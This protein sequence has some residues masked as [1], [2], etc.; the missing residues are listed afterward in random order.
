MFILSLFFVFHNIVFGQTE[1][2]HSSGTVWTNKVS[3]SLSTWKQIPLLSWGWAERTNSG[4]VDVTGSKGVDRRDR[5][6]A[7]WT[8]AWD[9]L[10]SLLLLDLHGQTFHVRVF[11]V[12]TQV[13][14]AEVEVRA[15]RRKS[16]G[17]QRHRLWSER[18]GKRK[19]EIKW[20]DWAKRSMNKNRLIKHYHKSK[21]AVPNIPVLKWVLANY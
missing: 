17:R 2:G 4:S 11:E 13:L 10:H 21:S 5:D 3:G 20:A 9:G 12:K 19:N 1:S 8:D 18:E 7:G 16:V 14:H 6:W 15:I